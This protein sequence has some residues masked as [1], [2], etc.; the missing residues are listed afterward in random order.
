[1]DADFTHDIIFFEQFFYIPKYISKKLKLITN[2]NTLFVFMS[3]SGF[4][5]L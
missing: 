4:P 2:D 5:C 1:M 3:I